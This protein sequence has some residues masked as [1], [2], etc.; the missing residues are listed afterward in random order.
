[1]PARSLTGA[2]AHVRRPV[3]RYLRRVLSV[4]STC[5]LL[6]LL[7]PLSSTGLAFPFFFVAFGITVLFGA[8]SLIL[9]LTRRPVSRLRILAW[10]IYPLAA[11]SLLLLFVSSQSPANPLFRLRFRLSQPA[12][13]DAILIAPSR[14][15]L[16]TPTWVG[17]F[18]IRRIDVYQSEIQFISDGCGVSDECGLLYMP[19]PIPEGRYKARVKHLRG[20]WYH[21]YAVF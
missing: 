10:L 2:L 18:P 11:S 4:L 20:A 9:G 14:K 13:E 6:F 3:L 17:L 16:A 19:G 1:V 15:P 5:W 8:V 21:L 7:E 12:L